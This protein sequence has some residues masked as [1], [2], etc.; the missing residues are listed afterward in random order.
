MLTVRRRSAVSIAWLCLVAGSAS[1]AP[2]AA[3][4]RVPKSAP[5]AIAVRDM[6]ALSGKMQQ[7]ASMLSIPM[8]SGPME[9]IEQFLSA[10]GVKKDGSMAMVMTAVPDEAAGENGD[11]HIVILVPV[12]DYKAFVEGLGGKAEGVT[13]LTK[14]DDEAMAMDAGGGY[15]ALGNTSSLKGFTSTPGNLAAHTARLG[16]TGGRIADDADVLVVVDI[17]AFS[18]QISGGIDELKQGFGMMGMMTGQDTTAMADEVEKA[19]KAM[20]ADASTGVMGAGMS[21]AG[22]FMD[23]AATFREGTESAKAFLHKGTASEITG[24]LPNRPYLFAMSMDLAAPA[25]KS[26]MKWSG[27]LQKAM[28]Q[29]A[30]P[31]TAMSMQMEKATGMGM[32]MGST[33]ALLQTGLFANT[34]SVMTSA[35]APGMLATVKDTVEKANGQKQEGMTMVTTYAAGSTKVGSVGVDTWTMKFEVDENDPNAMMVAQAMQFMTGA[36]GQIS[37]Q[38]AVVKN[39]VVSAMS[40][41]QQLMASV[42]DA[43]NGQN[44]LADDALHKD[45]VASLPSDRVFE[46]YVGVKPIAETIGGVM[47]MFGQPLPFEIKEPLPP[48]AMAGSTQ[49]GAASVRMFMPKAVMQK[50]GEITKAMN[51]DQPEEEGMDEEKPE[52]GRSKPKF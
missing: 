35:D 2:P 46:F 43:V 31:W 37:G 30:N 1:A 38:N 45:V 19:L 21:D 15:A 52:G 40:G 48:I 51:Q 3:L 50:I 29:G 16:V 33:P 17:P 24:M 49:G 41:D 4:D 8:E 11:D 7:V 18:Q 10:N 22:M 20:A 9:R 6:N 5:V 36:S 34:V 26:M 23:F 44:T 13:A 27:E 12:T 14:L 25:V 28:G 39:A 47:A 32:V 42:I